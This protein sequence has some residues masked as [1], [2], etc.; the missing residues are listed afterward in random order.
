MISRTERNKLNAENMMGHWPFRDCMVCEFPH[1]TTM[2][3]V[4]YNDAKPMVSQLVM[5]QSTI[6]AALE[7]AAEAL[8]FARQ[9]SARLHPE[10][11]QNISGISPRPH[12]LALYS[13]RYTLENDLPI[14]EISW[15]PD[16]PES[17]CILDESGEETL[18]QIPLP[19]EN[20]EFIHVARQAP[21]L[22]TQ[23]A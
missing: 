2:I 20:E 19:A 6:D 7:E 1:G 14:Y 23:T 8:E 10:F 11:W 16:W 3:Y 15:N 4:A 13:I 22:Y 21:H 9:I 12:P 18:Q 5:A 17:F